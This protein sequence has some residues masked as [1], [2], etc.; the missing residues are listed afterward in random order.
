[1]LTLLQS[2]KEFS[3]KDEF[4]AETVQHIETT[5]ARSLFNCDEA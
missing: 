5:L 2:K 1:M 3:T 4:Q